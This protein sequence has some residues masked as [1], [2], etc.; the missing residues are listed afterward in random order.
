MTVMMLV[1]FTSIFYSR[2]SGYDSG[3]PEKVSTAL[4]GHCAGSQAV[5][6]TEQ[7]QTFSE[8]FKDLLAQ[9]SKGFISLLH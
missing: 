5:F 9:R 3:T 6:T 2:A 8:A 7:M 1:L 4:T